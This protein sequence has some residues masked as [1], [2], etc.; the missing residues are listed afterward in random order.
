VKKKQLLVKNLHVLSKSLV[1]KQL[2]IQKLLQSILPIWKSLKEVTDN[3]LQSIVSSVEKMPFGI[4]YIA[5]K[6]KEK[7]TAKFPGPERQKDINQVVGNL[8]YYRYINPVIVSPEAFDVIET[9]V[10]PAQR[11]N[12]AEVAKNLQAISANR[13]SGLDL[14]RLSYMATWSQ[15]FA[16]FL[17]QGNFE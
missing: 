13:T 7:L 16:S 6:M 4:R 15:K 9:V 8:L 14:E 5:M 1:K 2:L 17:N 12:L 11:K 3:F 10:N